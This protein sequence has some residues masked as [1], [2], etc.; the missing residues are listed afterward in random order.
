MRKS[1]GN[2]F[3]ETMPKKKFDKS[4]GSTSLEL[5]YIVGRRCWQGGADKANKAALP[6]RKLI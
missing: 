6:L 2:D 4:V 1:V 5:Q 3:L